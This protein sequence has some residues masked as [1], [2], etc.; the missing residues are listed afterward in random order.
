MRIFYKKYENST[1]VL[2]NYAYEF[3]EP[4]GIIEIEKSTGIPKMIKEAT[5]E[6]NELYARSYAVCLVKE[7]YPKKRTHT[8][9]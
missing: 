7:N 9:I 4:D 1:S 3:N 5:G 8:A 2:Y 6:T